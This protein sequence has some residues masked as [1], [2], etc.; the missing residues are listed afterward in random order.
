MENQ[1]DAFSLPDMN[2]QNRKNKNK[3]RLVIIIS[4]AV[5]IILAAVILILVL[6]QNQKGKNLI[7]LDE[8]SFHYSGG[9]EG[10]LEEIIFN[11]H[12]G[13]SIPDSI[14]FTVNNTIYT[15]RGNKYVC[16]LNK[17]QQILIKKGLITSVNLESKSYKDKDITSWIYRVIYKSTDQ[18][19]L[20]AEY[21]MDIQETGNVININ[22]LELI[23]GN[24]PDAIGIDTSKK[25]TIAID[26]AALRKRE[27]ELKKSDSL[28][29]IRRR[30][31]LKN[32][33]LDSLKTI[34]RDTASSVKKKNT[35]QN[36]K[37]KPAKIDSTHK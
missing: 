3:F 6:K 36:E 15:E 30:D 32:L 33:K 24:I 22:S 31:S 20:F 28:A 7:G 13:I 9:I 11:L 2:R 14:K 27:E 35:E 19:P 17:L 10:R 25:Q 1:N 8:I 29:N 37:E 12:D 5:I 34:K 16:D 4:A 18:S 21:I 26:T 23:A